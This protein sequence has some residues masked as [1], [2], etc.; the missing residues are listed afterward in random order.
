[1]STKST[2]TKHDGH[3][4]LFAIAELLVI[5]LNGWISLHGVLD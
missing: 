3:A 1:M 5:L 2:P 4:V